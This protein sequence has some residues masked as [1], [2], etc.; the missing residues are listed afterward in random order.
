MTSERLQKLL[1]HAGVASRRACEDLIRE[2]R[3]SVN[4][5]VVTRLG[6]KADPA[7]QDIRVD[8]RRVR[9]EA[10]V[11]YALNKPRGV[12]CTRA[13]GEGRRRAVDL[14]P[15]SRERLYTVGR[16]DKQSEG[17]IILTNDGEFAQRI[18]HP[19]YEVPKTYVVDVRGEFG[20]EAEQRLRRGVFIEGGRARPRRLRVSQRSRARSRIE[21]TLTEGRKREIRR[22]LVRLGFPVLRLRRTRIGP[23]RLGA[24][25]PGK[26]RPLT[27]DDVSALVAASRLKAQEGRT[28][29]RK[30]HR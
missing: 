6:E 24:L 26:Y 7:Q 4:G 3:V 22:I 28:R 17:L 19:R 9:C 20:P 10:K 18:T 30:E 14:I 21:I 16:L 11:Y 1:A 23:L 2:G 27:A 12:V 15:R 25:A 8:G 29:F 13:E 5:H